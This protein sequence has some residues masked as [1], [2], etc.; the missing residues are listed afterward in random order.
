MTRPI[1]VSIPHKLGRDE[2]ARRLKRGLA[3]A[4]D[5]LHVLTIDEELWSGDSM[6]FRVRALGQA[7]S[8]KVDVGDDVVRLEVV[9]PYVLQKFAEM[10]QKVLRTRGQL[11]LE[12]K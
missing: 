9:L 5:S 2:A 1:V 10:A 11:L 6:T 4:S 12:K 8:G 7:A 3:T